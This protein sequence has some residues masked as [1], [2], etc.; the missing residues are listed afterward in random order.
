MVAILNEWPEDKWGTILAT[1]LD[2]KVRRLK[3][4]ISRFGHEG[5]LSYFATLLQSVSR[6]GG[7]SIHGLRSAV[8]EMAE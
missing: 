3:Q 2:N 6:R 1:Y 8:E 7:H 4:L 5:Q